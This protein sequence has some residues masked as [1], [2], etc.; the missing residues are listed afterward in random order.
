M[1]SLRLAHVRSLKIYGEGLNLS[2]VALK[3][4][5]II[6]KYFSR[7]IEVTVIVIVIAGIL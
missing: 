2:L 3:R 4:K 1:I 7:K 5:K 6:K